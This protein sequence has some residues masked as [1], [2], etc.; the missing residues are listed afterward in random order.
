ML[1]EPEPRS[2]FSLLEHADGS[3]F[4]AI[5][6]RYGSG[7]LALQ[8]RLIEIPLRELSDFHVE[9]VTAFFDALIEEDQSFERAMLIHSEPT[10]EW[11]D[12]EERLLIVQEYV[13]RFREHGA[14]GI[15][16]VLV[17]ARRFCDLGLLDLIDGHHRVIAAHV[18]SVPAIRAWELLPADAS[19]EARPGAGCRSAYLAHDRVHVAG[20]SAETRARLV[21]DW[22]AARGHGEAV[23]IAHRRADVAALNAHARE[24]LRT[25]GA[26]RGA[27]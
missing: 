15:E 14:A 11:H 26:L 3:A 22:W 5:R 1:L 6:D 10:G 2:L 12:A 7:L 19:R 16:P 8:V 23:M 17:D 25:A 4:E 27:G 20:T 9:D 21:T 24:L 18:A 13:S